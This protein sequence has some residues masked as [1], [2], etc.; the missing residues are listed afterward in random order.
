ME[1]GDVSPDKGPPTLTIDPTLLAA[2]T[3]KFLTS[4]ESNSFNGLRADQFL[5]GKGST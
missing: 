5:Q 2:I 4:A 3:H 1:E